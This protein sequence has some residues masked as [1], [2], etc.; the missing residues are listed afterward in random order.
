MY[1]KY[2]S[3]IPQA[4]DFSR[5]VVDSMKAI[6][7]WIKNDKRGTRY[8]AQFD[9]KSCY[10]TVD[11][12]I[13]K[14]MLKAKIKDKDFLIESFKII[15]AMPQGLAPGAPISVYL[16]HFMFQPLDNWI[17][18]QD[19]VVHYVRHMDDIIV[20][21]S[22]KKKLHQFERNLCKKMKDDYN[23][24]MH[25]NHQVFPIQ[26]TDKNGK[27]HG[28]PL[29]TCGYLFYRDRT[30]LRKNHIVKAGR[31][32]KKLNKKDK[33]DHYSAGQMMSEL[34][35]FRH[36]DVH[37]VFIQRIK[38]YVNVKKLKHIISKHDKKIAKNNIC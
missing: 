37:N 32:A 20:F 22:N 36:C 14:S 27:K 26:W 33:I 2:L 11:K 5:G 4:P 16:I 6:S 25:Y 21:G 10:P 15:D 35:L 23:M 38:P 18:Q 30:I 17:L 24:E 8:C 28:R 3:H 7:K 31:K 1:L 19:G 9:V 34:G 13:L 12:D 29:N